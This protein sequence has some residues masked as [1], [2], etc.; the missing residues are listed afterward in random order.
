MGEIIV[1]GVVV[2][3]AVAFVVVR[4]WRG[5]TSGSC[6]CA[7]SC[8]ECPTASACSAD[9]QEEPALQKVDSPGETR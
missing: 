2:V 9:E 3:A 4:V 8:A 6:E 5:A 1:V 7:G